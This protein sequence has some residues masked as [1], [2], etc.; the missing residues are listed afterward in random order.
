MNKPVFLTSDTHFS[1]KKIIDYCNRPF[2]NV[3]EMNEA[4]IKNWNEVVPKEAKVYHLGDFSFHCNH[5]KVKEILKRLN[6]DKY[7]IMGNHDIGKTTKWWREAGFT[8]VSRYPIIYDEFYILSHRP[9][10]VNS[11]TPFL[12][13]HGHT[14]QNNY[15]GKSITDESKNCYVNVCVEQTNYRPILFS[16]IKKKYDWTNCKD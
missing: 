5:E 12:S 2:K 1:H 7:L 16:D 8:D 14:H 6:G 11:S 9:V 4:L 13:I 3:E 15:V 10:F